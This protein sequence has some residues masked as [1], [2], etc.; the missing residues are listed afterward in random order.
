LLGKATLPYRESKVTRILQNSLQAES[1]VLMIV[2]VCSEI[3]N[4][5]M[6]KESLNFAK[7]AMLAY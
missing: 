6:T 3:Q 2:N 4:I 5:S 7:S 1:K